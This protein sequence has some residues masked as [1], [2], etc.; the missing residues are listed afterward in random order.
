MEHLFKFF[1]TF[2]WQCI[3]FFVLY[4]FRKELKGLFERI[5]S[6]KHN[7]T[8]VVFRQGSTN[9]LEPS[10]DLKAVFTIR[11]EEGFFTKY[12]IGD[13]VRKSNYLQ[14]NEDIVDSL[15]VFKTK[16]QQTWLLSTNKY[17]FFILDDEETRTAQRLIQFRLSLESTIQ[18]RARKESD[19]TGTF[20]LGSSA[21]WYY[22][23]NLLGS[24]NDA[25]TLLEDFVKKAKNKS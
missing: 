11:D 7:G 16:E 19:N 21:W 1:S 12:G 9:A 15:L 5:A 14:E 22:S 4:V 18:A 2:I 8:E 13:I 23:I 24:P 20:Q 25:E 6:V 3:V 10:P 17:I